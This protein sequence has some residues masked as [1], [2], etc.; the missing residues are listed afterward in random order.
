MRLHFSKYHGTGN[1]FII[2]DGRQKTAP[3]GEEL[4]ARICHRHFGIGADGLIEV[5][6]SEDGQCD[7]VMDYFNADG[8]I[9]SMCGNGARCA[10]HFA[11]GIG[12]AGMQATFQA[13]DGLHS[14]QTAGSNISVS[15]KDVGEI[16]RVS[17]EKYA[18]NTGSPH[19]VEF[20]KDLSSMDLF[21]EGRR[22][23]HSPA[24]AGNGINVNFAEVRKEAIRVCTY[25]RGV[26]D[27]TMSCGTG[28]TAVALAFAESKG[29][30]KGPVQ[31]LTDG[32]PLEVDFVKVGSLY[33]QI[34]LVGPVVH[35]FDA[36]IDT[37]VLSGDYI[38]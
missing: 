1:D 27:I 10:F 34:R 25:E 24:Y 35:V 2:I 29:L 4:I 32:G 36:V 20:V 5:Q 14:A 6:S 12:L 21:Q 9:G 23:R 22:I 3:L 16:T 11:Q 30:S 37:D 15:L 17:P 7:Y 26:E 13:Y 8:R 19:Y 28:V 33:S 38:S 18:L 31:V